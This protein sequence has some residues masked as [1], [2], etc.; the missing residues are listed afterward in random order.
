MKTQINNSFT[1]SH[2]VVRPKTFIDRFVEQRLAESFNDD[3]AGRMY[4]PFS[5]AKTLIA[6]LK[7]EGKKLKR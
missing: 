1:G 6:S 3:K 5:S 4:G 7:R 2:F